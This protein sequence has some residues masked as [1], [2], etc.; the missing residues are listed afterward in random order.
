M[1]C[2]CQANIP[3]GQGM[4]AAL[5]DQ[6][7][8]ICNGDGVTEAEQVAFL[9]KLTRGDLAVRQMPGLFQQAANLVGS[10]TRHVLAGL[11]IVS[12]D[13]YESRMSECRKCA[14]LTM[15]QRCSACGCFVTVKGRW[16]EQKCPIGRWDQG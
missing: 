7:F 12:D 1:K 15:E 5:S 10:V 6:E 13:Q 8:A 11:P 4:G 16:A 3:C 9:Q 14:N 2:P